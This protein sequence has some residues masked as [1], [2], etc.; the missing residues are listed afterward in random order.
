MKPAEVKARAGPATLD[1]ILRRLRVSLPV[2]RAAK[3]DSDMRR[4]LLAVLVQQVADEG[5]SL[6]V[7]SGLAVTAIDSQKYS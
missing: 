5:Q 3:I 1:Q 7:P 2:M 4:L 6:V